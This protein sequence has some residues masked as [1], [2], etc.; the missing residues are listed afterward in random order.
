MIHKLADKPS[1]ANPAPAPVGE[2]R[3]EPVEVNA[4][5][6]EADVQEVDLSD[7]WETLL[8]ESRHSEAT[9]EAPTPV[10]AKPKTGTTRRQE[11]AAVEEFHISEEP[12]FPSTGDGPPP[13]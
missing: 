2:S 6:L 7:E 8:E 12:R 10:E 5:P 4:A 1:P 3:L 11:P 9:V 13:A